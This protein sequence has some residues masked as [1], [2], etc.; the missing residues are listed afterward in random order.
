MTKGELSDINT[1]KRIIQ[2]EC[3]SAKIRTLNNPRDWTGGV[4][5]VQNA[6]P[7]FE[8]RFSINP[9]FTFVQVGSSKK[10]EYI[11]LPLE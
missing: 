1:V 10:T 11:V 9:D 2:S 4:L 8:T 5:F 7:D 6:P 3:P